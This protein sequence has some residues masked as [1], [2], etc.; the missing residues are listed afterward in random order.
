MTELS[1]ELKRRDVPELLSEFEKVPEPEFIDKSKTT[2]RSI[3]Q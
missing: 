1:Y 3:L 2:I